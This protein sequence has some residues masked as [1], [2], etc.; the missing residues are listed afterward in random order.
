MAITLTAEIEEMIRNKVKSGAY[1]SADD[2]IKTSLRLLGAQEQGMEALRLEIM[3]G[4]D[5]I[6]QGRYS[7]YETDADLDAF[8]DELIRQSQERRSASD[9]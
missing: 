1:Q 2:V 6:Q 8:S 4:V 9:G 5:D 3:R 7:S